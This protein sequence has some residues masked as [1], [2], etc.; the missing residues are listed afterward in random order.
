MANDNH[1]FLL[2]EEE[3]DISKKWVKTADVTVHKEIL[4]EQESIIVPVAQ[5]V[6]V[7]EKKVLIKD[8]DNVKEQTET[9]RIPIS[10]ERVYVV[11]HSVILE[12]VKVYKQIQ[13]NTQHINVNLKREKAFWETTGNVNVSVKDINKN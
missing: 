2:R 4:H 11:K 7:I 8:G 1:K 5:E 3:L 10:E 9:I 6:L 12:D 13:Q